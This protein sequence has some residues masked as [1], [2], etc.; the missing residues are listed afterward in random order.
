MPLII[1]GNLSTTVSYKPVFRTEKE[2]HAH[3]I[4][5]YVASH[6]H[7]HTVCD[8]LCGFIFYWGAALIASWR[9]ASCCVCVCVWETLGCSVS[10]GELSEGNNTVIHTHT[11]T[12]MRRG[13]L[14]LLLVMQVWTTWERRLYWLT[15]FIH[16]YTSSCTEVV[17]CRRELLY[18]RAK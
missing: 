7:S 16:K 14:L 12:H 6:T 18:R 1:P 8:A 4:K 17:H 5:K 9:T 11:H 15:R 2:G 3:P 13:G 10:P